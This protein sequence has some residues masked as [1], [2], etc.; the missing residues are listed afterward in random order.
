MKTATLSDPLTPPN[1]TRYKLHN[2]S[3]HNTFHV[4]CAQQST[5]HSPQPSTINNGK[6]AFHRV[7]DTIHHPP[8]TIHSSRV[9]HDRRTTWER[10]SQIDDW[11][12]AGGYP[13]A[14]SMAR[15]LGVTQRTVM[16]DLKFM[17]ENRHLPIEYDPRKYGF[18]YS[19]PVDGFS[20]APMS[21]ADIFAIMVAHKAIAQHHGTPF[22]KPLRLAFQRLTGQLDNRELH[23]VTNLGGALSFRPFAPED[24]DLRS[25]KII[26]RALAERR[27]LRFRYRNWGDNRVIPRRVQPYHLTCFDNRWYLLA[28]DVSRGN[29][30]TYALCRLSEPAL[31][32][33]RFPRPRNFDPDKYLNG[34]L[35]VMKGDHNYEVVIEFDRCGTDLIR[36]RRWHPSQELVTLPDGRS[37]LTMCLSGL[38]EIER[39]VLSWGIHAT[40][41]Q[42]E[43]LVARIGQ[44]GAQLA[45]R[46]ETQRGAKAAAALVSPVPVLDSRGDG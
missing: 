11:I 9:R 2:G 45:A 20:K 21:Q 35:G 40:V 26:T 6:D 23:S 17:K 12:R 15:K 1:A 18:Y 39:A 32:R 10:L 44:I 16:R 14:R 28:H 24:N 34:S 4:P 7:P 37:R 8:S 41:I 46:Y 31:T 3:S 30:R 19:K 5:L 38:E 27:E 13:N 25:F 42:P 43:S 33:Q 36:G 22:E 29:V